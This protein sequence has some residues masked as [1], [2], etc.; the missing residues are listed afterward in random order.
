MKKALEIIIIAFIMGVL[1]AN[2]AQAIYVIDF[3]TDEITTTSEDNIPSETEQIKL[4][5]ME[6]ELEEDNFDIDELK[7]LV[8]E[9][10]D[11]KV[12]ASEM[13]AAARLLGYEEDNPVIVLAKE[14]WFNANENERFYQERIDK[15]IAEEKARWD[16][17]KNEYPAA[18]QIWLYLKDK[19]YNDYVCA[20]IMGNLMAEVGGQTL[21]LKCYSQSN[22]YY[23][24]CQWN[25]AYSGVWGADITGQ[26]DFLKKT[27]KYEFDTYGNLYQKGFNYN[28][29][30][31]LQD[32]RSAAKA[33]AKC[34][35]RC[36][37]SS[38]PVRQ[39]NAAKAY[40]YFTN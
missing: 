38:L 27:I 37:S 26:L 3:T 6:I 16:K 9:C 30:L 15:I 22:S 14:E 4:A 1:L 39:S 21:N 11:R 25:K 7:V 5:S 12:H 24:M 2:V 34:Y 13:A 8:Q 40:K 29:F 17:K 18:T 35:E 28:S 31:S 36:G 32:A 19:G 10:Q 33:F 23:G 20:G